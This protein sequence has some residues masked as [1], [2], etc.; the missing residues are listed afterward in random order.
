MRFEDLRL[1]EPLL[2]AV[3][4]ARYANPTPIQVHAIP[5]SVEDSRVFIMDD[6]P[7]RLDRAIDAFL[8]KALN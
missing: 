7:E 2:R 3:R 1:T 4:T 8:T 5:R 6:Q